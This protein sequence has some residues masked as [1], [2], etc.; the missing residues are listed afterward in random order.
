MR[1]LRG[2]PGSSPRINK[3]ELRLG[4]WR[5]AV[6]PA[7]APRCENYEELLSAISG[8]TAL[9]AV[10]F[11]EHVRRLVSPN[12]E[13]DLNTPERVTLTLLFVNN[14]LDCAMAYLADDSLNWWR[15]FNEAVRAVDYH[16]SD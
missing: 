16:G 7:S 4:F 13:K 12:K 14:C 11:F 5:S 1:P 6:Q 2:D 3:L 8:L 10:L 9:G 15:N